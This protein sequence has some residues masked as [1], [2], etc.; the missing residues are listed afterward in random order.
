MTSVRLLALSTCLASACG[1]PIV[2][3]DYLGTPEFTVRG[4]VVQPRGAVNVPAENLR[5]SLFWIGFDSRNRQRPVHEQHTS[6]D[7]AFAAF[8]MTVF[9]PPPRDALTFEDL[10]EG[11][12]PIGF[13]LIVLYADNNA[14]GAL[15]SYTPLPE[16]GPD[17]VLGASASHLVVY[18]DGTTTPGSRANT[19]LGT[20]GPGFHLFANTGGSTCAFTE[21]ENC[22]GQG[23]L[24]QV[25]LDESITLTLHGD[26]AQ[27]LV[28][29]PEI[30]PSSSG[31]T[32][33]E[34]LYSRGD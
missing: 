5:L 4:S 34:N 13:A 21:S 12:A 29:N 32:P 14:N 22:K 26:V 15:N 16:D 31:T 18:S 17:V 24:T 10:S 23:R 19:M 20:I 30:P 33:I 28:P 11:G 1:D 6:L 7:Q 27:V 9:D 3:S 25:G 2:G 8:R